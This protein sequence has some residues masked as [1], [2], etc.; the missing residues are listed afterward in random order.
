MTRKPKLLVT[1]DER[2]ICNFVKS[3]FEMRGFEVITALNGDEA[4]AKLLKERPDIVIMDVVMR[5]AREGLE[6][7]PQIKKILPSARVLMITGV[8][9]AETIELAQKLGADDYIT[10]PLV[11]EHLESM[12]LKMQRKGGRSLTTR[13]TN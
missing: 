13:Q 5:R 8:D 6:Y 4:M 3:F 1:D 11:L 7:L 2:D 12:V 10:K 9:D